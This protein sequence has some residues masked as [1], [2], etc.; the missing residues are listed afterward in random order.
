[1]QNLTLTIFAKQFRRAKI[2][3]KDVHIFTEENILRFQ[4]SGTKRTKMD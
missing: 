1:M 2:C 4:V 3:N